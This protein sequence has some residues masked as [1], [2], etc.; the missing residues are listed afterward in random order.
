MDEGRFGA[1]RAHLPPTTAG[2]DWA[3]S[4]LASEGLEDVAA[5]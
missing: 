1:M 4:R 2:F 5:R 3:M